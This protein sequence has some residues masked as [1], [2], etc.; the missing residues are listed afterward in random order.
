M[1]PVAVA[2]LAALAV[3]FGVR[4]LSVIGSFDPAAGGSSGVVAAA[5]ALIAIVV[6]GVALYLMR[7][8]L[9]R[10]FA[11]SVGIAAF[12]LLALLTIRTAVT[13]TYINYDYTKEFLFYAHGAPGVKIITNQIDELAQR[14]GAAQQLNV[15]WSQE[16]SW[17]MTWY[18]RIYP[19]ARFFGAEL[20]GD[21]DSLQ[22]IVIGDLDKKYQE[23]TDQLSANYAM[24][25][26]SMVWWPMEDYKNMDWERLA[27]FDCQSTSTRCNLGDSVQP[28]L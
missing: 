15:G 6:I 11:A 26:Y 7:S 13:V 24:F 27:L 5:N 22:V 10:G 9:A 20:P 23:W 1:A 2:G 25:E 3:V 4:L 21:V 14:L 12:G 19:G 17:P 18:M 8:Y 28:Q 16:T